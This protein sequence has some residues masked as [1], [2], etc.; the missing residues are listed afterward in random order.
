[1]TTDAPY[2]TT[3]EEIRVHR[4]SGTCALEIEAAALFAATIGWLAAGT[5]DAADQ[6][7]G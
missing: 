7:A 3:A 4:A 5:A 6:P 1:V 2:R